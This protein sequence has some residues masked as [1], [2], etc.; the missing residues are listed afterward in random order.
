MFS[1]LGHFTNESV[2][3][4]SFSIKKATCGNSQ[5]AGMESLNSFEGNHLRATIAVR[6]LRSSKAMLVHKDH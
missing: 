5:R 3:E 4:G 1:R 6:M 2:A